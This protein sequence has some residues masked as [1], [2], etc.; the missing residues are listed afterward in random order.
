M[1]AAG[2]GCGRRLTAGR[3]NG[4]WPAQAREEGRESRVKRA[5]KSV[6]ENIA[7]LYN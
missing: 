5:D 6:A 2:K 3:R 1:T 7:M 4:K